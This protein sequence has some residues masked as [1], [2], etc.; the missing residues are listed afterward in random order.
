MLADLL[1][2]DGNPLEDIT[3]FQDKAH[4][5]AIMKEGALRRTG[6]T[7]RARAGQ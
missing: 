4:L 3:L 7:S 6:S 2:M 5:L 1:V